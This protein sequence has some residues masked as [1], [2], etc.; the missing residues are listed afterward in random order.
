MEN[1][2]TLKNLEKH[3]IPGQVTVSSNDSGLPVIKV[4]TSRSTA[5]VLPR[6]AHVTRFQKNGEPPLL[7]TSK[8]S[9]F[10]NNHLVHSGVPI[11]FPWFGFRFD[12]D[13][14]HGFGWQVDW[15]LRGS[16]STPDGGARLH[17][18]L[19]KGSVRTEEDWPAFSADYVVT[20]GDKLTIEFIVTNIS[21]DRNFEF[22]HSLHTY[23]ELGD[24]EAVSITGLSGASYID[25]LDHFKEKVDSA[26]ALR[27]R[28]TEDRV[29]FNTAAPIEIHDSKLRRR[30]LLKTQG[31][32]STVVWNPWT[33][34]FPKVPELAEGEFRHMVCVES[35]N[36]GPNKIILSPGKKAALK[37]VYSTT[38]A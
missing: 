3:E 12:G 4:K 15:E 8:L 32:A 33:K 2:T 16:D 5:E 6:G 30:I 7:F 18:N 14:L 10:G 25:K 20:V 36:V 27:I 34:K 38:P 13:Q 1:D 22:E 21:V 17:F 23:F 28:S 9:Q 19:T 31:T 11:V 35:G 37:V 24:I 26:D 29:Y